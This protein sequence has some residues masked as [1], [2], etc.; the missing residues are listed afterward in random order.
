MGPGY[1]ITR[2][3]S[4]P[5]PSPC[6][7]PNLTAPTGMCLKC[8]LWQGCTPDCCLAAPPK[9]T[10]HRG[11]LGEHP[12][13][14]SPASHTQTPPGRTQEKGAWNSQ[15]SVRGGPPTQLPALAAWVCPRALR[16]AAPGMR[17][18]LAECG[19]SSGAGAPQRG[20]G[21]CC[22]GNRRHSK[23]HTSSAPESGVLGMYSF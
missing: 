15:T 3:P 21:S 7:W 17:A 22:R 5:H 16:G 12:A 1:N 14:N 23:M 13:G 10:F 4:S 6:L 11:L 8:S 20:W 9:H 18:R 2:K 19:V